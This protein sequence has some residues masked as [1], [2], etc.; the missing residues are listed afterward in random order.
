VAALFISIV[1]VLSQIA[2]FDDTFP[3]KSR[4]FGSLRKLLEGI[5]GRERETNE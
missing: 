1:S 4:A 5:A 2:C 3:N